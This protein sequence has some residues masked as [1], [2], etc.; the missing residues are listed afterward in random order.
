M[1]MASQMTMGHE[2]W[3][4]HFEHI[5]RAAQPRLHMRTKCSTRHGV[6]R[7]AAC[8]PRSG[9]GVVKRG[10]GGLPESGCGRTG[11]W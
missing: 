8:S 3:M 6:L 9:A 4:R 1:G 10:K 7:E 2:V 5:D 11:G